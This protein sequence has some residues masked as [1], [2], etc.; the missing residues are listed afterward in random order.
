MTS[1]FLFKLYYCWL[2]PVPNLPL[3][4][5][6]AEFVSVVFSNIDSSASDQYLKRIYIYK[7]HFN[8]LKTHVLHSHIDDQHL[9]KQYLYVTPYWQT[10]LLHL[11][12]VSDQMKEDAGGR[13]GSLRSHARVTEP[14]WIYF[15]LIMHFYVNTSDHILMY[16]QSIFSISHI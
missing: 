14:P 15:T 4:K 5:K 10:S 16:L 1:L 11:Q 12:T 7:Q 2:F 6:N 8:N 9:K 3:V 13:P